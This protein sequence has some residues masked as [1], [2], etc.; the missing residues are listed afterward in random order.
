GKYAR[1]LTQQSASYTGRQL[2]MSQNFVSAF[3]ELCNRSA[4]NLDQVGLH[5]K[6]LTPR[7]RLAQVLRA[8]G[9]E[10]G[11]SLENLS[12]QANSCGDRHGTALCL[13]HRADSL[14]SAP[15]AHIVSLNLMLVEG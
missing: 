5:D 1:H 6:A 9:D 11:R 4:R 12:R 14:V 3:H 8:T 10:T 13:M 2:S 15:V 7:L